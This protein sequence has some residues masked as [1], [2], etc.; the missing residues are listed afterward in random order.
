V[1]TR[2]TCANQ[3]RSRA[4]S[5]LRFMYSRYRDS[6]S[7]RLNAGHEPESAMT[8]LPDLFEYAIPRELVLVRWVVGV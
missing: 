8:G 2:A 7:D 3:N 4:Y 6:D 1:A 5:S